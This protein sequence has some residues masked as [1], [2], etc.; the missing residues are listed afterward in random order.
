[1]D[2]F[3][4]TLEELNIETVGEDLPPIDDDDLLPALDE[5]EEI[6]E[7]TEEE[8]AE[9][10]SMVDSYSTDDPVRMY[11]KEIGKVNL[12]TQE[13]EIELA[14]PLAQELL[15]EITSS[16]VCHTDE[17][18]RNGT[19]PTAF[20]VVLGHEGAGIVR[21]VG[22]AVTDFEV[23]DHVALSFGYCGRCKPCVSGKPYACEM[24]G[25]INFA[26]LHWDGKPRI[27]RGGK[28]IGSFFSQSSFADHVIVNQN[29]AV[30]IDKDFDLRL[31]G[32]LGCGIQTGAGTVLNCFRPETGATLAVFGCGAVGMSA[33]MAAR[34]AGCEKII[35][36]G[37]NDA[38]LALALELGA[39]HTI[40]RKRCGDIAGEIRTITGSGADFAVE[41]SGVPSMVQTALSSLNY[42]GK[43]APAGGTFGM[44]EFM[45]GGK[46]L[47][48]VTEG[49]SNPKIFIPQMIAYQRQGRFPI[50][51][52][53]KFYSFDQINEAFDDSNSGRTIK[54]VLVRREV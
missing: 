3:Y 43:L 7:V 22:S 47:V 16:G 21:Q 10:D 28:P 23:G 38:S 31:A 12:L 45:L 5:L 14:E 53:M 6:D 11:L 29:S 51:K 41:T 18:A 49:Y 36:V 26:G 33:L 44:G 9:A 37:G 13:E 39:T 32:P 24:M 17:S 48:G 35:A 54:A 46:S 8:I 30:K 2:R 15:V 52:L 34:L 4:D 50:E 25:P 27:F 40:N 20:P 1:M 19:I 42:L